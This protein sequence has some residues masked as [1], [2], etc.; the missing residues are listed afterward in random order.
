MLLNFDFFHPECSVAAPYWQTWLG[1]AILPW[2][3]F[4]P[5]TISATSIWLYRVHTQREER[6]DPEYRECQDQLLFG[7]FARTCMVTMLVFTNFA[8]EKYLAP[9]LCE[10]REPGVF[11]LQDS[12]TTMCVMSDPT[13]NNLSG[14]NCRMDLGCYRLFCAL[15]CS[16]Q[17]I[18]LARWIFASSRSYSMVCSNG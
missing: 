17:S 18:P 9:F 4:I 13:Y 11:V 1:F 5:L 16:L 12:P 8:F 6:S 2:I 15:C 3:M 14:S 7:A 10:E